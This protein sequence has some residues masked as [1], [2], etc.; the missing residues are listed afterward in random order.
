MATKTS[1]IFL[2]V[3]KPMLMS[4]RYVFLEQGDRFLH[5]SS[6]FRVYPDYMNQGIEFFCILFRVFRNM[7]FNWTVI[8]GFQR[9]KKKDLFGTTAIR[10]I[11]TLQP[12]LSVLRRDCTHM[13][14]IHLYIPKKKCIKQV[15]SRMSTS[16]NIYL[17]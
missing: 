11:T 9:E 14:N 5:N 2:I 7:V 4:E 15:Y 8:Y 3:F 6:L 1:M 13:W 10:T 16:Q 17:H 12:Y